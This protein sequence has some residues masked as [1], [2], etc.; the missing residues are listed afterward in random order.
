MDWIQTLCKGK[1]LFVISDPGAAKAVLAL[2]HKL[3][4]DFG[5][6]D[7]SIISDRDHTFFTTFEIDVK[8]IA[9][10][11]SIDFLDEEEVDYV[12]TGTSYS[13]N[14]EIRCIDFFKKRNIVTY[15]FIDHWTSF[16]ERFLLNEEYVYPETIFVIDQHAKQ[17]AKRSGLPIDKIK[18]LDN[19]YYDFLKSWEP[20]QTKNAWLVKSG[21]DDANHKVIAFLPEPLSNVGGVERFG[22][23]ETT[24]TEMLLESLEEIKGKQFLL[25][26][27]PH[28][29]Q[30]LSL[31]KGGA[32]SRQKE[33]YIEY[34]IDNFEINELLYHC[35]LVIGIFSN[36]LIEAKQFDKPILR[37]LKNLKIEDPLKSMNVGEVIT[38]KEELI[39]KLNAYLQ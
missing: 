24:C 4:R 22:I 18:V 15:S 3:Q 17:L 1:G 35:D 5:Y 38:S 37:I 9:P 10:K 25:A 36:A 33:Q 27:K 21:F 12:F 28:P 7:Y 34:K 11:S 39:S 23:D 26:I 13:S 30:N 6:R 16:K 32:K 19:P 29:N 31:L 8:V 20:T 2:V 14:L